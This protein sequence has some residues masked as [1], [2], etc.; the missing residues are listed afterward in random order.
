MLVEPLSVALRCLTMQFISLI[1]LDDC[2][3]IFPLI[4]R[5]NVS[6]TKHVVKRFPN[7]CLHSYFSP[8]LANDY[9]VWLEISTGTR[10]E[11]FEKWFSLPA[12]AQAMQH[13]K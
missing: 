8:E 13:E 11:R 1:Q 5:L 7:T 2:I 12:S 10:K 3:L 4:L 9:F 6:Q